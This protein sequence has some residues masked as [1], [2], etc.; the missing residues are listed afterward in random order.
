MKVLFFI[1]INSH[2]RGGHLHS[3]IHISRLLS[4]SIEAK[5]I[6]IGPGDNSVLLNNEL[7]AQHFYFNGLNIFNLRKML[8]HFINQY[9]PDVLHFFD[10]GV[11]NILRLLINLKNYKIVVNKCGGPNP[12]YY[13]YTKNLVLFSLEDLEWFQNKS[14]YNNTNIHLIPNRVQTLMPDKAFQPIKKIHD[15]FV[16]MRICRIGETY[17]KSIMDAINLIEVLTERNISNIKLYIIGVVED[18]DVY[19]LLETHPLVKKNLLVVLSDNLYTNEASKMLYLADAVIGTGR[20]LMEA[21][22]L[23]IP[24][25]AINSVGEIPVLLTRDN[26]NDAFRTNFSERNTFEC[27]SN[28]VNLENIITLIKDKIYY[29]DNSR[30]S[31]EMFETYFNIEKAEEAYKKVYENANKGG[32][33]CPVMDAPI[34]ARYWLNMCRYY[35][36]A[37]MV[38]R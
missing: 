4:K 11:Y 24:L 12:K 15:Q 17:R 7:F 3:L 26:F 23:G 25:L 2:G 29:T 5:I 34:I 20:G 35:L 21:A 9:Q 16:F 27:F 14:K 13:P 32:V 30:F 28:E 37:K 38:Q 18:A 33:N 36:K 31:K 1:S 22:S 6:S 19:R 10:S 8:K